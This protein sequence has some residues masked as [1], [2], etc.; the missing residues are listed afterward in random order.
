MN[1]ACQRS[2]WIPLAGG[3]PSG[4]CLAGLLL[5]QGGA[6]LNAVHQLFH[7]MYG[8]TK[9]RSVRHHCMNA[10]LTTQGLCIVSVVGLRLQVWWRRRHVCTS[11]AR[12][13][14]MLVL[15]GSSCGSLPDVPVTATACTLL[16]NI[17][18]ECSLNTRVVLKYMRACCGE[19]GYYPC[20]QVV[21]GRFGCI[22]V[23]DVS[24][25]ML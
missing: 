5:S 15:Q 21:A 4:F 19:G 2:P 12:I 1:G 10:F 22:R 25:H 16:T 20:C 14:T 8:L 3:L 17:S 18:S 11:E 23:E 6:W 9:K 13:M 7:A 24:L